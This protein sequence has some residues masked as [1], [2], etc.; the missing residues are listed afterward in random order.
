MNNILHKIN[1]FSPAKKAIKKATSI[2]KEVDSLSE[3]FKKVSDHELG[4]MT[5]KFISRLEKGE[6]LDSIMVE[7]FATVREAI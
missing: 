3:K 1:V 5:E 4:Q 2:A 6:T 7:A